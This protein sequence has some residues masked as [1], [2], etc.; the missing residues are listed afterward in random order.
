MGKTHIAFRVNEG[1]EQLLEGYAKRAGFDTIGS[2]AKALCMGGS[3]ISPVVK[4]VY[5][6]EALARKIIALAGGMNEQMDTW[7]EYIRV[8][9]DTQNKLIAEAKKITT[10][11][12]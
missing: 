10:S 4:K 9:T 8:I 1:E 12:N 7:K 3:K 11:M 6:T 5:L 2:Y